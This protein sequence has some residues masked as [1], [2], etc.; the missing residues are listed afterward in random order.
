MKV[1][2][3]RPKYKQ[4]YQLQKAINHVSVGINVIFAI[5]LILA[6][7]NH[8]HKVIELIDQVH[9]QEQKEASV[10]ATVSKFGSLV[11][12]VEIEK[13]LLNADYWVGE[14]VD[15]YFTSP[16][17]QSEMRM[18]MHC[19]LN[20]ETKHD[21]DKGHGDGG[22][23][24]GPL[25][26]HQPT[27]EGYRKIMIERGLVDEVGSRYDQEQAIETTVWAIK[28]GRAKAWGPIL[29][30]SNGNAYAHSCPIPSWY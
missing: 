11:K 9:A 17:Q 1:I 5:L 22:K 26:F 23:A 10:A 18:I 12:T 24:G 20:R 25:Q 27:W 21:L 4:K 30:W 16:A 14:Y 6:S 8:K 13:P 28:D 2:Y 7:S 15:K 29:R 3:Q 19:L